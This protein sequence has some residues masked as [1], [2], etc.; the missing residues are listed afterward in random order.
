MPLV[1]LLTRTSLRARSPSL[2]QAA[3][4]VKVIL[5]L[6]SPLLKPTAMN[7]FFI[8]VR[9]Y[10]A[11]KS[12]TTLLPSF[13]KPVKKRKGP[14]EN[15]AGRMACSAEGFFCLDFFGAFCIKTKRTSHRG[16]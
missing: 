16:N 12:K 8:A 13:K 11:I 4:R 1:Y 9:F 7:Y 2:P 14:T 5:S 6:K 15:R 10:W 3:N